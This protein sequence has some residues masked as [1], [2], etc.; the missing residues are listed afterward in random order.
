MGTPGNSAAS[1]PTAADAQRAAEALRD[2]H[3]EIEAVVLFGS[4]AKNAATERSDID[5]LVVVDTPDCSES[6][7]EALQ[8]EL[9]DRAHG[10]TGFDCDAMP[11]TPRQLAWSTRYARSSVYSEAVRHGRT[12]SGHSEIDGDI[13]EREGAAWTMARNDRQ[14]AI[15]EIMQGARK[16]SSACDAA[17]SHSSTSED[18]P[19]SWALLNMLED[20]HFCLESSLNAIGRLRK[21]RV[22][23]RD[24]KIEK[25]LDALV[26]EQDVHAAVSAALGALPRDSKGAFTNWRFAGYASSTQEMTEQTNDQNAAD[27]LAAAAELLAH[28]SAEARSPL[29]RLLPISADQ[30][31]ELADADAVAGSLR[32]AAVSV[33]DAPGSPAAPGDRH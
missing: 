2:A 10:V 21:G 22:L 8:G 5:L 26:D 20:S 3:P 12:L 18:R 24:H 17:F 6:E 19:G 15:N 4:V 9:Q 1:I 25:M 13:A 14:L 28:A 29:E 31:A 16:G 33:R 23:D 32:A 27:H 30:E 11:V 7:F